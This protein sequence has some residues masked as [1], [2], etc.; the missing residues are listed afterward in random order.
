MIPLSICEV[1][2]PKIGME[3][4][5]LSGIAWYTPKGP[6][7][8]MSFPMLSPPIIVRAVVEQLSTVLLPAESLCSRPALRTAFCYHSS[9]S[10]SSS[11]SLPLPLIPNFDSDG[12]DDE[13][14]GIISDRQSSYPTHLHRRST[15]LPKALG[16]MHVSLP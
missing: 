12:D 14:I 13:I 3:S 8:K 1:V 2:S 6:L 15:G 7:N 10:S 4:S 9:S 11:S 16:S 5:A